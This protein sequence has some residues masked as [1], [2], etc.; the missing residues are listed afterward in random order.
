MDSDFGTGKET[1]GN[2]EWGGQYP[3][4]LDALILSGGGIRKIHRPHNERQNVTAEDNAALTLRCQGTI[5][6]H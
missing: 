1:P 5:M 6:E 2:K 4:C 3:C